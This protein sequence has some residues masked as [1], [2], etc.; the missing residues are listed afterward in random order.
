VV[1][2][3]ISAVFF[4]FTKCIFEGRLL[5]EFQRSFLNLQNAF[6]KDV[7]LENFSDILNFIKMHFLKDVYLENFSGLFEV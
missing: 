7:Y 2:W 6:L 1:T 4:K 5:G 3:R